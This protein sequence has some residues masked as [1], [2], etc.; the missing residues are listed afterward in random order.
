MKFHSA[1][2]DDAA[3]A[4]K[5]G[6][7]NVFAE[8]TAAMPF[9]MDDAFDL[10]VVQISGYQSEFSTTR[11]LSEYDVL[12]ADAVQSTC[13]S[14]TTIARVVG[15]L[16]GLESWA[17]LRANCSYTTMLALCM[18]GTCTEEALAGYFGTQGDFSEFAGLQRGWEGLSR[19]SS[20]YAASSLNQPAAVLHDLLVYSSAPPDAPPCS[21]CDADS[22][23]CIVD[24]CLSL[25]NATVFIHDALD[26]AVTRCDGSE[27]TSCEYK[28]VDQ[29]AEVWT[30]SYWGSDLGAAIFIQN[31]AA[32]DWAMLIVG[33]V[34][35]V[36]FA[37]IVFSS[38]KFY[39][40]HLKQI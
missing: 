14:A 34:V 19:Y 13:T 2:A 38:N 29:N 21:A 32:A 22:A 18:N 40:K 9:Y 6:A 35:T 4:V 5:R 39:D 17:S 7:A 23:Q 26:P 28:I 36:V 15:R 12:T 8:H 16:A 30:E 25:K 24:K 37:L 1:P 10:P 33:I 31:S 27:P 3:A 11:Y 20:V